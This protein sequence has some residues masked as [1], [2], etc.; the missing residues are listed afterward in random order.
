[1]IKIQLFLLIKVL[2]EHQ[3]VVKCI[4]IAKIIPFD[5]NCISAT[6]HVAL[7]TNSTSMILKH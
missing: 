2:S 4:K 6:N 1:M 5:K 3:D 7:V